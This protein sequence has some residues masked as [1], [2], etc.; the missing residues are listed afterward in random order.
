[1]YKK[2]FERNS[3]CIH[4]AVKLFCDGFKEYPFSIDSL[5]YS[6]KT[7]GAANL[8]TLDLQQKQ[9]SM[10][11]FSFDD[12]ESW[13][14]PYPV[15]VYL[16]QY[17]KLLG[18]WEQG[19]KELEKAR[20]TKLVQ[21]LKICAKTAYTHFKSDYLQTKFSQLKRDLLLN[22]REIYNILLEERKNAKSLLNLLYRDSRVGF[23][24][25]N[26]Y[27]YTERNLLEKIVGLSNLLKNVCN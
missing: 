6:P 21:E 23:E 19:L 4:N 5:Y 3:E 12:Y 17:E 10:V 26:Q 20:E 7:L 13:T 8:W 18:M 11:C 27:Y 9:S 2:I 15:T 1:M 14:K 24:A 22:R 25:S 16:S